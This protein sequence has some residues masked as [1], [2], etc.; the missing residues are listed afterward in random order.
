MILQASNLFEETGKVSQS[1]AYW[2]SGHQ[3]IKQPLSGLR[4]VQQ[5]FHIF[6]PLTIREH[7]PAGVYI[8]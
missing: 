6:E 2:L 5:Q 7:V 3:Q 8:T 4:L 1:Y